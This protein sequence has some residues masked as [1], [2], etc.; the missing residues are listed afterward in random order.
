MPCGV[1]RLTLRDAR[2]R[3][4]RR[5]RYS[6]R[7]VHC[8]SANLWVET[9]WVDWVTA[10]ASES[11]DSATDRTRPW[12]RRP[13]P[14]G[15]HAAVKARFD[16]SIRPDAC[17]GLT[18]VPQC[19]HENTKLFYLKEHTNPTHPSDPIPSHLPGR[20]RWE[21]GSSLD[22]VSSPLDRLVDGVLDRPPRAA[23]R[24]DRGF[25]PGQ[26]N[27]RPSVLGCSILCAV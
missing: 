18:P 20:S 4:W 6:P 25:G 10:S 14:L 16:E 13:W 3:T 15:W 26:S 7:T 8:S 23:P 27:V 5:C 9:D 19:C 1:R 11:P 24:S 12:V 2:P 17:G 22:A 21:R